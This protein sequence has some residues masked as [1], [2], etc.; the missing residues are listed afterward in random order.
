MG[1]SSAEEPNRWAARRDAT[2]SLN[3]KGAPGMLARAHSVPGGGVY[4]GSLA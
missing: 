1:A 3:G 4:V 2:A